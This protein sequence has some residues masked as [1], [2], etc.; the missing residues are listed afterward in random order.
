MIKILASLFFIF[1]TCAIATEDTYVFEAKGEF[2]KE[3]KALVEKYSKEGKI[4][5]KVFVK[6]QN[7]ESIMNS[8][9]ASDKTI[10]DGKKIYDKKCSSCHGVK[11]E[12]VP[13]LG[14]RAMAVMSKDDIEESIRNYKNDMQFGGNG[15]ML[16]QN[17]A[18]TLRK[19]EL[20]AILAYVHGKS[21]KN[22]ETSMQTEEEK[23]VPS[24]YLQ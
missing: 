20:N 10:M 8:I 17:I 4:D 15:K 2:A 11:G 24:N 16:M 21:S 1:I 6:K 14:A 12:R 13:G 5:A 3:L 19:V 22:T 7:D 23:A 18:P 9:F